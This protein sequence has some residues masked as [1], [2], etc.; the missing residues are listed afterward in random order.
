MIIDFVDY[1]LKLLFGTPDCL[2]KFYTSTK[3]IN[4]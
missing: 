4:I 2:E 3:A 1:Q